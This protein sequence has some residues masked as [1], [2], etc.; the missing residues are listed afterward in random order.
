[1]LWSIVV[2]KHL[3]FI[4]KLTVAYTSNIKSNFTS[5]HML[6]SDK[7]YSKGKEILKRLSATEPCKN[8]KF[9]LKELLIFYVICRYFGNIPF[10]ISYL[11]DKVLYI[12]LLTTKWQNIFLA[13]L[14]LIS[15]MSKCTF[16]IVIS[17]KYKT[18]KFLGRLKYKPCLQIHL[19]LLNIYFKFNS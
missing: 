9:C 8:Q 3:H 10:M 15:W 5:V 18:V 17:I 4:N 14:R 2:T 11:C 16:L 13:H 6:L 7:I 19:L 12:I 1:M